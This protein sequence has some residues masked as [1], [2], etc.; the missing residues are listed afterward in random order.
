MHK[1][2]CLTVAGSCTQASSCRTN[3]LV[4]FC[5]TCRALI[6]VSGCAGLPWRPSTWPRTLTTCAT[7]WGRSAGFCVF[8]ESGFKPE[9]RSLLSAVSNASND[10][11][12]HAQPLGAGQQGHRMKLGTLEL[13]FGSGH[14]KQ[15]QQH[16]YLT[17]RQHSTT[18]HGP[19]TRALFTLH[20][21]IRTPGLVPFIHCALSLSCAAVC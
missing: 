16:P 21:S 12:L 9:S 13:R 1:Q 11:R 3:I 10:S 2:L 18:A 4:S 20:Q 19:V 15:Q 8:V 6:G 5:A 14:E 17:A 7:T